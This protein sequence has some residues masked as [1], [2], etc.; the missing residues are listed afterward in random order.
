MELTIYSVTRKKILR[1][2]SLKSSSIVETKHASFDEPLYSRW[3][4]NRNIGLDI[5]TKSPID[6]TTNH[7]NA[8]L[9]PLRATEQLKTIV[10]L[11]YGNI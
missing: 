3:T 9:Q 5:L 7:M 1:R 8:A 10:P 2:Q 6:S 4:V 11:V